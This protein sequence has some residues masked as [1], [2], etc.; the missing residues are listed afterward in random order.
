MKNDKRVLLK[1]GLTVIISI[2]IVLFGIAFLKETKIGILTN[3]LVVYFNDVN[4]LKEGDQ[5]SVNGVAKGKV[6][7]IELSSGDSVKVEFFLAKD[8][9]LKKDYSVSV[10]MIELMSGKQ[11]YI[12]PGVS[13][14]PADITKPLVGARNTDVVS[15]IGTLNEVGDMVKHITNKLDTAIDNL[16]LT[17]LEIKGIVSDENLKSNIRGTAS[18]FNVASH[19]LNLML[20]DTR[21]KIN[22]LTDRL[23]NVASNL[24]NTVTETKPELKQTITDIRD[25]TA[26]VDTLAVNLNALVVSA[27]DTNSTIGKL[28]GEDDVYENLN[29]T[30]ISINKLVKKI[31]KDGIRLRL[32]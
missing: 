7:K 2:L 11:I 28:V 32:F 24:D 15:L 31:E 4:G 14:E 26:K 17:V 30:I 10:A 19:N 23:N 8:V 22:S 1:V 29:K 20:A 27:K 18:N 5:V 13:N 16:D 9:I 12:K 3:D 6:K 21:Q 25:L